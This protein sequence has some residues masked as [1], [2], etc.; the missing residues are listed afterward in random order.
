MQ[1]VFLSKFRK[2]MLQTR[3]LRRET[4]RLWRDNSARGKN[5]FS[6]LVPS[7]FRSYRLVVRPVPDIKALLRRLEKRPTTS[8]LVIGRIGVAKY[9]GG[10]GWG[11]Y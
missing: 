1:S 3:V 5:F 2:G 11:S 10:E 9:G 8:S 6:R 4:G 7:P